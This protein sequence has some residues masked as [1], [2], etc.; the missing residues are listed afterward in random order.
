MA[1]SWS[2][3]MARLWLRSAIWK[4]LSAGQ[5]LIALPRLERLKQ[6]FY[7]QTWN[8]SPIWHIRVL[9]LVGRLTSTT[10][11]YKTPHFQGQVK[12][13]YNMKKVVDEVLSLLYWTML[14]VRF[15]LFTKS[16]WRISST[17]SYIERQKQDDLGQWVLGTVTFPYNFLVSTRKK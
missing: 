7:A 6:C 11:Q 12:H 16:A 15:T 4:T 1:K 3:Q 17:A 8:G 14:A 9:L 13:Q 5:S 2:F 10:W